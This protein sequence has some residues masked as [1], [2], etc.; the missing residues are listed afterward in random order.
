MNMRQSGVTLMELMIVVVIIGILAAIAYP[1]YR[2]QAIRSNRSEAKVAIEQRAQALE[3]CFTRYMAYNNAACDGLKTAQLTP[4]GYYSVAAAVPNAS[5]YTIT[6]T[7]QGG[8][9]ADTKC[10]NLTLD[11]AGLRGKSGSAPV[12]SCW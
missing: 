5:Q 8:Q 12:E 3:K 10:L 2:E 11:E 1:S 4:H 9:T 6:A 7:P